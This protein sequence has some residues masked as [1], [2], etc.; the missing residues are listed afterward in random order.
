MNERSQL[1]PDVITGRSSIRA[2]RRDPIDV[3]KV[4]D[5]IE[6][7]GW[8]PSPHGTQ[9]WR[10]VVVE[11]SDAR[12]HLA[13]TMAVTWEQ[14]LE[15]DGD[16]RDEILRRSRR[17]QDRLTT[18]PVVVVLCLD[19]SR[20]QEYPDQDRSD[21]EYLMAVQSLGAA[22]QNFLLGIFA[23]GLDAGWMCAPL[24][25]PEIVR[26]ALGLANN[27]VPHA[28]FPVGHMESPPKRRPRVAVDELIANWM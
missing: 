27:L 12:A 13:S 22:A 8:A 24:F 20:A 25:V 7:A 9:P 3:T 26:D 15:Q 17:S 16:H 1:L 19:L 11:S 23:G 18:A 4:R 10:F 2:F 28:M 6:L 21:A 5:A 14:Q